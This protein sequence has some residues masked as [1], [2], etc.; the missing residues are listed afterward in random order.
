MKIMEISVPSFS[1]FNFQFSTTFVRYDK[2][3]FKEKDQPQN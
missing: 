3:V 1:T 2:V